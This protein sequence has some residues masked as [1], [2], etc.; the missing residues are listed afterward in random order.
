M[1]KGGQSVSGGHG[2][3]R[4][5]KWVA[6]A[7][8]AALL[9]AVMAGIL[10]A[11]ADSLPAPTGEVLLTVTGKIGNTN[12]DGEARFDREM[13]MALG[14]TRLVTQ[15]PWH[16]KG[17]VFEGVRA[18]RLMQAVQARGEAVRATAANDYRVT[19]PMTD[20]SDHNVLLAM[21]IGGQDLTLRTKGPLW[22]IYPEES[23]MPL[24]ERSERMIWQLVEL[25]VE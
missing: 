24:G 14:M 21:R 1:R 12:A 23:D 3:P 13:L 20:F 8:L 15:T 16:A 6:R 7:G 17:T 25:R 4:C 11:R 22:V 5:R 18:D 2:R 9:M 10:D 19:I